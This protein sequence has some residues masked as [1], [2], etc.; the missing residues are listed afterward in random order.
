MAANQQADDQEVKPDATH[1]DEE[2]PKEELKPQ[3]EAEVDYK[4]KFANSTRENQRIMEENKKLKEEYSQVEDVMTVLSKNPELLS[5]VQRAYDQEYNPTQ[6][7][8]SRE[9]GPVNE[10]VDEHKVRKV[11]KP[12]Q[13]DVDALRRQIN[14]GIYEEFVQTH[15]DIAPGSPKAD[16]FIANLKIMQAAGVPF[17]EGAENAYNLTMV[18]EVRRT[19]K[20][21]L[22]KGMFEKTQA[23]AGSGSSAT[24][25]RRSGAQELSPAEKATADKLGIKH[26]DYAKHKAQN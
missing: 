21:E 5:Q 13:D 8:D 20:T 12:L 6:Q 22:L 17:K 18:D 23:S 24:A 19:G 14:Q 1:G 10:K 11:V 26:E 16:K 4:E 25:G 3:P 2:T 9:S 15:P 7:S